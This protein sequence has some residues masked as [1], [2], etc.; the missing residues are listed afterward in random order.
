VKVFHPPAVVL[1]TVPVVT[2]AVVAPEPEDLDALLAQFKV[3]ANAQ[4]AD[5][6]ALDLANRIVQAMQPKIDKLVE[7]MKFE[8]V[9]EIQKKQ[10]GAQASAAKMQSFYDQQKVHAE[11]KAYGPADTTRKAFWR[12]A[13]ELLKV[14]FPPATPPPSSMAPTPPVVELDFDA[15]LEE[16]KTKVAQKKETTEALDLAQKVVQ[17]MEP[18]LKK[19]SDEKRFV[20]CTALYDKQGAAKVIAEKMEAHDRLLSEAADNKEFAKAQKETDAFWKAA[21]DF[22]RKFEEK[23]APP[24]EQKPASGY[25]AAA[26]AGPVCIRAGCGKPTWNGQA[27]FYCSN[28]CKNKGGPAATPPPAPAPKPTAICKNKN[29]NKEHS[30]VVN[31]KLQEYCSKACH[32]LCAP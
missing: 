15:L 21:T 10:G 9:L 13:K 6:D 14:F 28:G 3:M 12:E 23:A 22:K 20:E 27:G 5:D 17:A 16:F 2:P 18:K 25:P 1:P 24:P 8:E 11:N 26:P 19:L 4:Q 31:G 30:T 32:N 29:C 7:E